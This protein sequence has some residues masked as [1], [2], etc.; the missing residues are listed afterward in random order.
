MEYNITPGRM[1]SGLAFYGQ[2][3]FQQYLSS[4]LLDR[5][6]CLVAHLKALTELYNFIT[7][8]LG[9]YPLYAAQLRC[10]VSVIHMNYGSCRS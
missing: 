1:Q 9:S 4:L 7:N 10:V 3:N 6:P 2:Q 8:N 5:I